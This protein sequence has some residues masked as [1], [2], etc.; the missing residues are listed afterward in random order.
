MNLEMPSRIPRTEYSAH[1]HWELVNKVTGL[2]VDSSSP[3][4]LR[5]NASSA[6]MQAWNYDM[7][8]DV[9]IH[10]WIFKGKSTRMGHASYAADGTDYDNKI[11]CPFSE[12]EEVLKYDPLEVFGPPDPALFRKKFEKHY[13][14][15]CSAVPG[16]VNMSGVYVTLMSGLIELFGWEM[17]LVAAGTDAEAFGELACRYARYIT[18]YFEALALSDVPVVM[19]HD[20]IVWTSGAFLAPEW[21]RRF[22]FPNYR[23]M[24]QP[25]LDSGKKVLYTSDGN[26]TE[27]ID[28]IAAS[29]VHGFVLEPTTDMAYIAQKYGRTHVFV[30]NADTRIL[31]S[32]TREQIRDEVRRCI[33]IGKECPGFFM[34]VGN[35]IPANTPVENAQY[36]NE[37]YEELS[38]R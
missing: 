28:D 37:V 13:N 6:F 5:N 10:A 18:L 15:N 33:D 30:G 25:L 2:R 11:E 8:W 20:D 19:V 35:H 9:L 17:L 26:Y 7:V 24:I 29:G 34:A 32:G 27:F 31:L 3:E 21:Y 14:D 1:A 23:N 36:Y 38:R 4:T 12:P 16:A 22:I